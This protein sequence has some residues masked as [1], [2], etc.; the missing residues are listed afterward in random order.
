MSW[1][2]GRRGETAVL[3]FCC[4]CGSQSPHAVA[5]S[6]TRMGH[7]RVFLTFLLLREFYRQL[8]FGLGHFAPEFLQ[9]RLD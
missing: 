6:A 4:G 8:A 2:L 1:M 5:Q 3:H 9:V 7:P